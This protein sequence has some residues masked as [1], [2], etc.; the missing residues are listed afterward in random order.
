MNKEPIE[1]ILAVKVSG[2]QM[3]EAEESLVSEEPLQVELHFDSAD[4]LLKRDAGVIMRTPGQDE[5]LA[6][7][8]LYAEGI[9]GMDLE[10]IHIEHAPSDSDKIIVIL[11]GSYL[12]T[13]PIPKRQTNV[14]SSCG[15]C[16]RPLVD[17]LI[18]ALPFP[19]RRTPLYLPLELIFSLQDKLRA[20]QQLF[21]CTGGI[22]AA[23]LFGPEG[24]LSLLRE[25]IGRH[26]A[27]DKLVGYAIKNKMLP[28]R[29]NILLLSGRAGFELLQKAA[30]AGISVVASVGAPS[31]LAVETAREAGITLIG[32]L[33]G[34]RFNIYTQFDNIT[35]NETKDQGKFHTVQA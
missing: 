1:K 12:K 16:G 4:G 2:S 31:S 21:E 18:R 8:F 14:S 24:E 20:G 28:L 5:E 25:D 22:H 27:V 10:G 13:R 3:Q 11:P 33:R 32:F 17:D 15:V 7:G 29:N 6:L 9:I 30:M 26:N 23:G 35:V 34:D 19:V